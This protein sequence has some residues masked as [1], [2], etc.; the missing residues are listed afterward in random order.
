MASGAMNRERESVRI[1]DEGSPNWLKV[2]NL[3]VLKQFEIKTKNKKKLF[4]IKFCTN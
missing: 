3:F 1:S 4:F 2:T